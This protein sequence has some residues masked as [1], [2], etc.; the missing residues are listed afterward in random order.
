MNDDR[1]EKLFATAP[2]LIKLI[3]K[4]VKFR[5]GGFTR[6]ERRELGEDLLDLAMSILSSLD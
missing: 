4:L 1:Q 3:V 5:K 6:E 2:N